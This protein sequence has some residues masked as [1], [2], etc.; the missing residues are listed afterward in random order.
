MC[1]LVCTD[2][3]LDRQTILAVV[4]TIS[5]LPDD[6]LLRVQIPV[7]APRYE[8]EAYQWT[9]AYWPTIYKK[10]NP[11]GPQPAEYARAA[12]NIAPSTPAFMRLA[13][14]TAEVAH[15]EGRGKRMGVVV[16][17]RQHD[18]NG[19]I[20]AVA[21]DARAD[22]KNPLGHAVMRAIAFVA[23]KIRQARGLP[24]DKIPLC[25]SSIEA[26]YYSKHDSRADGYLCLNL[27]IYL[28]HEP[29]VMCSMAILHSRFSRVVFAQPMPQ[30][31]GLIANP[32]GNNPG[33]G[34]FW[35]PALNW[36]FLVWQWRS[37]TTS[38]DFECIHV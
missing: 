34:L 1:V 9:L 24:V 38:E 2:D 11:L 20:V 19:T 37:D 12:A 8:E 3:C 22:T 32:R 23:A 33:Y 18:P 13:W 26:E 31:G 4:A 7:S 35:R 17:N 29:C 10:H 6:S 16:V 21:G 30:T 28:T 14:Q 36:K 27:E 5:S 25:L 15:Q